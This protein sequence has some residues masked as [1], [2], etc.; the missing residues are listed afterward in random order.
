MIKQE[1]PTKIRESPWY[2]KINKEN[3]HT[4]RFTR[5]LKKRYNN[6]HKRINF[7]QYAAFRSNRGV[8]NA[9]RQITEKAIPQGRRYSPKLPEIKYGEYY[10]QKEYKVY[11]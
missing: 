8:Q 6:A 5:K 10:N 3:C 11:K 7:R 4:R 2:D 9:L 1:I